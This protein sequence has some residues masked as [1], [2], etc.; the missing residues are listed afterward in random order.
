[1]FALGPCRPLRRASGVGPL[2]SSLIVNSNNISWG[3]YRPCVRVVL[4]RQSF[5]ENFNREKGGCFQADPRYRIPPAFTT[6]PAYFSKRL[7]VHLGWAVQIHN[8][9]GALPSSA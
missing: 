9:A 5:A 1:M 3:A 7:R 4:T 6:S 8:A 2:R